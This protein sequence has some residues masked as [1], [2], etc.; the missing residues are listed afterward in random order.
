MAAEISN[1]VYLHQILNLPSLQRSFDINL[2]FINNNGDILLSEKESGYL[3]HY[4]LKILNPSRFHILGTERQ[5]IYHQMSDLILA[6]NLN[7]NRIALLYQ[8]LNYLFQIL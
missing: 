7:L 4:K 3:T 8:K 2:N 5:L 1:D 6:C